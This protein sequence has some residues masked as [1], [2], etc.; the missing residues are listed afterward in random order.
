MSEANLPERNVSTG[1]G[2][3]SGRFGFSI[4]RLS[5]LRQKALE[6]FIFSF[7]KS[8]NRDILF[9]VMEV[10]VNMSYANRVVSRITPIDVS[11]F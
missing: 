10:R 6:M 4:I 9:S 11:Y 2:L 5:M 8:P 7:T 3:P 1:Y